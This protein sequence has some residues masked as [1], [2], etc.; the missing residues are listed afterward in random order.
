MRAISVL[1]GPE[2]SSTSGIGIA[3]SAKEKSR[4]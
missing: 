1:L 3:L 4:K 2:T